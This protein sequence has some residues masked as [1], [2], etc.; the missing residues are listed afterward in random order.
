MYWEAIL[1][2]PAASTTAVKGYAMVEIVIGPRNVR[3]TTPGNSW[4][5][6]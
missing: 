3:G 5:S 6:Y 1:G 4:W 2:S